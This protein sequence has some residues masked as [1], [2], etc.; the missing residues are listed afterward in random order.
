VGAQPPSP[1]YP[2]HNCT[3]ILMLVN[4]KTMELVVMRSPM[5]TAYQSTVTLTQGE[6]NPLAF[7]DVAV[8]VQRLLI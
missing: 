6:L 5:Q 2:M 4:L 7:P 1:H 3:H 8:S